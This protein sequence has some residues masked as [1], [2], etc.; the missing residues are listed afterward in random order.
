MQ[1]PIDIHTVRPLGPSGPDDGRGDGSAPR[2]SPRRL[3]LM[4]SI[5]LGV[6]TLA[7]ILCGGYAITRVDRSL[8]RVASAWTN[9]DGVTEM[10]IGALRNLFALDQGEHGRVTEAEQAYRD[11]VRAFR[12]QL[13]RVRDAGLTTSGE[14]A[15]AER[16]FAD[17]E[18]MSRDQ[19]RT[20]Q[21]SP[22]VPSSPERVQV[23]GEIERLLGNLEARGD[24]RMEAQLAESRHMVRR[25]LTAVG[26]MVLAVAVVAVAAGSLLLRVVLRHLDAPVHQIARSTEQLR[27]AAQ[28]QVKS[29]AEQSSATVQISSTMQE[30]LASYRNMTQKSRDMVQT[31]K[32]AAEECHK[33]HTFL[34]QSQKG[35]GHIKV[36]VGRIAEHMRTLEEKSRQINSVVEI[37]NE[38]ASQTNLLSVNATIEAAGAG[39]AGRRFA[40]VAEE[41]RLLAERAVESTD[42]IRA[43]IEDIQDTVQVTN[44]VTAEGERAVDRGLEDVGR[45][46]D[47][48]DTLLSLVT[49]TADAVQ[50]I[51]AAAQEQGRAVQQVTEA[52]ESLS[53]ISSETE[54]H[55]GN[56]LDTIHNLGYTARMLASMASARADTV[57]RGTGEV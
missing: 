10:R 9:A 2:N 15:D 57:A 24:E 35:I 50:L 7:A 21:E 25:A 29:A 28:Y 31:S 33:G 52:V 6:L 26:L 54:R 34:T 49:Q 16:L 20:L 42:E 14:L 19:L 41:I 37:I 5:A 51:E 40:V 11:S 30:L 12:G 48:F 18:A 32:M 27:E 23:Q 1:H 56:T 43:L 4:G 3:W 8:D 13:D 47:N 38:M 55:S 53:H 36:E 44:T 45:I 46:A 39:E 22:L 17:L